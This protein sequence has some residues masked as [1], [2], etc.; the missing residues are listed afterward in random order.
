VLTRRIPLSLL[1]G[2]LFLTMLVAPSSART[3]RAG[4]TGFD[5]QVARLIATKHLRIASPTARCLSN[6]A[7]GALNKNRAVH[8]E[9]AFRQCDTNMVAAL[10]VV[11]ARASITPEEVV[12]RMRVKA[13][14][15]RLRHYHLGVAARIV[16]G[17]RVVVAVAA[18]RQGDPEPA[19]TS[20]TADIWYYLD[21][22]II[23]LDAGS[24]V[25][26]NKGTFTYEWAVTHDGETVF[27]GTGV[28][29][30]YALPEPGT[31]EF[32]LTLSDPEGNQDHASRVVNFG[33]APEA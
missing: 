19:P 31:Y 29:L 13:H 15:G 12:K 16:D 24:S 26:K 5:V 27:I 30:A 23:H 20:P 25:I 8:P 14:L 11:R 18:R 17:R 4:A 32:L 1:L 3:A 2:A 6:V 22:N 33:V 9:R 21:G 10:R 28:E 7:M